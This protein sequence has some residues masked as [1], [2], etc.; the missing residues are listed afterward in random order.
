M[1]AKV[2]R[3]FVQSTPASDILALILIKST[4]LSPEQYTAWHSNDSSP[5]D[6]PSRKDP[7]G[8][9]LGKQ[10]DRRADAYAISPQ[11]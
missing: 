11:R 3:D 6:V 5:D 9:A 4:G 2:S 8:N 1:R 10:W 7:V